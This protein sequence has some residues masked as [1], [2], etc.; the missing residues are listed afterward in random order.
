MKKIALDLIKWSAG[1]ILIAISIGAYF[2]YHKIFG[3]F[4]YWSWTHGFLYSKNYSMFSNFPRIYH[5]II[6][7]VKANLPLILIII[8]GNLIA[9]YRNNCKSYFALFF[10]FFALLSTIPGAGYPH[11]FAQ[12]APA[13][14]IAGG[15]GISYLA[16]LIKKK[17]LRAAVSVFI[18][19]TVIGT[20]VAVSSGYYIT[21]SP[22]Q[23]S[24]DIFGYNPFPESNDIAE[25]LAQR[26]SKAE[27]VFIFG[28]EAQIFVLSQRKSATSFALIYPMMSSYPRYMEFQNK[29]WQEVM[30]SKPK[31]IITIPLPTSLLYDG[32]ADLWIMRQTRQLLKDNYYL[33]A[34]V[35]PA[36]PK[37][38]LMFFKEIDTVPKDQQNFLAYIYKR[39]E[40]PAQY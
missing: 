31:Y 22:D 38:R 8:V 21:K 35:A 34:A 30:T 36:N 26:T 39:K 5:V 27:T 32:K 14:A 33:E 10:L 18:A 16:K 40:I 19:L 12:I 37:G 28:S 13:V 20:P 15:F 1:F 2:Y 25:F 3:E 23:I 6:E 11:Y 29:A 7:I 9:V 4:F 17:E 24:R